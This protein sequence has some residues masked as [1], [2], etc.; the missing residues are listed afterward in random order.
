MVEYKMTTWILVANAAEARLLTSENLRIGELT[1]LREFVHPDSRKRASELKSDHPGH[2]TTNA[3][4]HGAYSKQD[5]TEIEAEHFAIQLAHEL[6]AG[7]NKNQYKNLIIITPAH[8][9]GLIRKHLDH[10]LPEIVHIS[11]NYTRYSL[12]KLTSSLREHLF[13]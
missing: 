7:W 8:F 6:K 12:E 11:K 13:V 10:H 3:G 2:Y 5:P 1:L 9:H 4:M